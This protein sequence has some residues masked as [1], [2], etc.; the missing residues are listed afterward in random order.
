MRKAIIAGAT[1]LIGSELLKILLESSDYQEVISI[2]RRKIPIQHK[3][4]VQLII[5]FDELEKHAHALKGD[6]IF[7]CLGSTRKKTPD[8]AVYRKID[9]TYPLQLGEIAKTNHIKQYHLVSALG[10]DVKSS[11]FYTKMKGETEAG[12]AHLNL[13]CLHI[14]QP[15]LL[16]GDR[17]ESR[18]LEK[19]F[20]GVMKVIDPLLFGSLKKY[21][22]IPAAIVA[23]AMYKQSLKSETD[24]FIH[25]SDHINNLA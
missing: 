10:A 6:V 12:L 17:K 5:D 21:K 24:L 19:I 4:L 8:L 14:Y 7:C 25:P 20:T 9:Y 18:S 16:T 15:S 11:N 23:R 3:K 2:S 1:G 22:S 13:P